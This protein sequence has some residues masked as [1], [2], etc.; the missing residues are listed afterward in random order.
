MA[1]YSLATGEIK[2]MTYKQFMAAM[3]FSQGIW[4]WDW[5]RVLQGSLPVYR[6]PDMLKDFRID[7]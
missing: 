1:E 2:M 5:S 7:T 6:T 3:Q 4:K